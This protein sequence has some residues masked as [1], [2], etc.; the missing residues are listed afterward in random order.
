MRDGRASSLAISECGYSPEP[1][2]AHREAMRPDFSEVEVATEIL[3]AAQETDW[4]PIAHEGRLNDRASYRYLGVARVPGQ[5][6]WLFLP[7]RQSAF[8]L[9]R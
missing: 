5:Q 1:D 9:T 2:H 4:G 6:A 8:R 7:M 3:V